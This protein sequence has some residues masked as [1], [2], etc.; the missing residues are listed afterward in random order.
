MPVPGPLRL[1]LLLPLAVAAAGAAPPPPP[2][3]DEPAKLRDQVLTTALADATR[4]KSAQALEKVDPEMLGNAF[5]EM[6]EKLKSSA[7]LEFLVLFT[8]KEEARHLRYVAAWAAWM[9]A[10]EM[11]A[12]AF[13]EKASV[14]DDRE[15]V[16]AVEAAGF[17]AGAQRDK[18]AWKKLMEIAKGTRTTPGIEAARALDRAMERQLLRD[19]TETAC[20]ASDNHVRKHLVWAVMDLI[21]SDR[22]TQKTFEGMRGRPGDVG[23]NAEECA[24]VVLDKQAVPF[25]W[26][27]DALKDAPAW[28]KA[29]RPKGLQCEFAV[30]DRDQETK[31][32]FQSWFNELKKVNMAWWHYAASSL[33]RIARRTD[34]AFEIFDLKKKSLALDSSEILMCDTPWRGSYVLARDAGI[35]FSAQ[36]G[37]PSRDHR[38]WEPA[39]VDLYSYMK[40]SRQTV[41]KFQ[42][43][44][45]EAIAKK[46]WP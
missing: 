42:D 4:V 33:P 17:V 24:T 23:K 34:K 5:V 12:N 26:K 27:S 36:V 20:A 25:T 11:A 43:W 14:E 46:P 10:P 15:A 29:G 8:T 1:L 28:W 35:A 22:A 40:A 38:G 13:L 45:D 31:D 30:N 39:Y 21:G 41:G 7:N 6:G 32:K 19:L 9:S 16:R 3:G 18:E 37:E 2:P 44:V